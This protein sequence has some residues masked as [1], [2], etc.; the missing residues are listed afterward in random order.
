MDYAR[1]QA[2]QQYIGNEWNVVKKSHQA[3]LK[4]CISYP[5]AYAIGMSNLGLR[6]LYGLFN[7]FPD[8]VCERVFLPA[9]DFTAYLCE[10]KTKLTSLETKTPLDEFEVIGFNLSYELNF[11]NFLKILSLGAVALKSEERKD[12]IVIGGGVANPEPLAEFVDVFFLGEFEEVALKFI[13]ILRTHKD[14]ESRLKA[15]CEQE[16]FYVPKYYNAVFERNRYHFEKTYPHARFPLTRV[17]VK[18]LNDAYYPTSWLV[19][20][21]QIVHD[22]VAVEIARGCPNRCTFCQARSLYYPYRERSP[23][24]VGSIIR[25]LY[26]NTGYENFSLL[27]LSAS[28]YSSIENLIDETVGYFQERRV[29]LALP[30]LRIDDITGRL[31]AKLLALKKTTLTCALEVVRDDLRSTLNKTLDTRKLFEA[32]AI[33]RSLNIRHLKIYFMFG[34]PGETHED[35]IAIGQFLQK[36]TR[37]TRI[38]LNVSINVFVPKPFS[39]WEALSMPEES[40]LFARRLIILKN[41]PVSRHINVTVAPLK[42]SLLEAIVCRAGREFSKVIHRI[43]LKGLPASGLNNDF[44]WNV[45]EEAMKEESIDYHR[46]LCAKTENFP[47]SFIENKK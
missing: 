40:E 20:H 2:P 13:E 15:L 33:L 10:N 23:K 28:D 45:W 38:A 43:F 18:N 35:L 34:I 41:I 42:R 44:H 37:E 1:F 46:Y 21:N 36:V 17:Y 29:G 12:I 39:L 11:T 47:W 27:S 14:K 30:S 31:Y 3:K 24:V 19:P 6:I 5:D 26:Q 25:T 9:D 32:A 4:L 16:G 22:R 7:E 8:V